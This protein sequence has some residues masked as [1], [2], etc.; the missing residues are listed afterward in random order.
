MIRWFFPESNKNRRGIALVLH[1][2][3][4]QPAKMQAIADCLAAQQIQ[5]ALL[6]LSGHGDRYDRIEGIP[7][8]RARMQTFKQVTSDGW[9]AEALNAY[10]F[11]RKEADRIGLPV[12]LIGYSLGGLLA[13]ELVSSGDADRVEAMILF[14]PAIAFHA[15]THWIKLLK[16]FSA[17]V[18]PS[19]SPRHYRA[20]HGMILIK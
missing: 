6:S 12:Q 16:P 5:T 3:N 13:C 18:I 8:H 2:L 11:V 10:H 1:G 17:L 7:A 4:L 14:A 9:R 20:N 19:L 15:S